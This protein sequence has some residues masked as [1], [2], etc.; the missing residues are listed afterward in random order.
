MAEQ[1]DIRV[2]EMMRALRLKNNMTQAELASSIAVSFQQVQK[3]E[4]GANRVSASRLDMIAKV[5]G[6]STGVFFGDMPQNLS[7]DPVLSKLITKFEKMSD[8][9]KQAL[10]KIALEM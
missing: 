10:L 4:T 9:K 3:Y 7:V 2:G 5:F 1:V 6:V 8:R